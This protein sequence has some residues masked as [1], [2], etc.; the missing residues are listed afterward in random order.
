MLLFFKLSFW[1]LKCVFFFGGLSWV[2]AELLC[3]FVFICFR[4]SFYFSGKSG[5]KMSLHSSSLSLHVLPPVDGPREV[6]GG[7]G[8]H[9]QGQMSPVFPT[10]I[11]WNPPECLLETQI[12]SKSKQTKSLM[13]HHVSWKIFKDE[14]TLLSL[15]CTLA[16]AK[17]LWASPLLVC[18][19]TLRSLEGKC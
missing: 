4:D 7:S 18:K 19:A 3:C 11:G 5:M 6:G 16:F 15:L 17:C 2:H 1:D 12:I 14:I 10:L 9:N 8:T 13:L